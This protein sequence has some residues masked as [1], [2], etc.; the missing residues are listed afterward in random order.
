MSYYVNKLDDKGRVIMPTRIMSYIEIENSKKD[1]IE[2]VAVPRM[3]NGLRYVE[4]PYKIAGKERDKGYSLEIRRQRINLNKVGLCDF[5]KIDFGGR[6]VIYEG[7]ESFIFELWNP[8]NFKK[9][10]SLTKI[11]FKKIAR[12]IGL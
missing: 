8:V 10:D 3:K 2:L 12:A 6:I 9:Y 11:S 7:L 4:I 1:V 5:L